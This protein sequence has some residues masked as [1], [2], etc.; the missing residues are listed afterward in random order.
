MVNLP[1][2]SIN[3]GQLNYENY[4]LCI[5]LIYCKSNQAFKNLVGT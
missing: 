4:V 3:E 2:C 1:Q 5:L